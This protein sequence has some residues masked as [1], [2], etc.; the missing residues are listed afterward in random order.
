MKELEE[1]SNREDDKDSDE[2]R[3]ALRAVWEAALL[4]S[5]NSNSG[6][7]EQ[8]PSADFKVRLKSAMD[9]LKESEFK[10]QVCLHSAHLVCS[11]FHDL[12]EHQVTELHLRLNRLMPY[13]RHLERENLKRNSKAFSKL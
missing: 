4:E 11:L 1:D 7:G 8:K 2:K 9:N 3:K 12:R 10:L 6:S 5:V 13:S